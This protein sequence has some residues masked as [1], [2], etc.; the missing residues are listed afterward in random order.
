MFQTLVLFTLTEKGKNNADF[1]KLLRIICLCYW[2]KKEYKYNDHQG[3]DWHFVNILKL[4][5][6]LYQTTPLRSEK[7][8][9]REGEN[10]CNICNLKKDSSSAFL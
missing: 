1:K 6:S 3:K 4:R 10:I 9:Q 5:T 2:D 7:V 8:S